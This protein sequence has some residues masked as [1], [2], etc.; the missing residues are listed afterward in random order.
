VC[1]FLSFLLQLWDSSNGRE[2]A[3]FDYGSPGESVLCVSLSGDGK[4]LVASAT[5]GLVVVSG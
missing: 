2:L 4:R 5:N 1:V 3:V